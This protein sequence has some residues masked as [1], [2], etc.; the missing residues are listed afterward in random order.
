M[1]LF[2]SDKRFNM[3]EIKIPLPLE[4]S[5]V[6]LELGENVRIARKR[7]RLLQSELAQKASVG[8]KTIRRLE[9]GDAGVSVGNVLSVL[10]ALGLL[11]SAREL[12]DP[13]H[14]EHGKTLDLVRLPKRIRHPI[15]NNDF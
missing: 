10:W 11:P 4:V 2:K 5:R 9:N 7:R 6:A 8:E 12:A 3:T 13:D 14:D 1:Y 15:P